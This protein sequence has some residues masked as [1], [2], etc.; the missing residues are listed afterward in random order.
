M[1]RV[2]AP[3]LAG[4]AAGGAV[5]A[6]IRYSTSTFLPEPRQVLVSTLVTAFVAMAFAGAALAVR[7]PRPV[8]VLLLAVCGTA[9]SLSAVAIITVGQTPWLALSFFL[10]TPI[11]ALAGLFAGL[12]CGAW[13]RTA[14]RSRTA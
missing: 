6:L 2:P 14:A 13:L 3:E 12:A 9:A 8:L 11:A 4:A 10:L 5:G 7:L 1:T